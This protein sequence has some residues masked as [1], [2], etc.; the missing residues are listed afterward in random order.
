MLD[1][2]QEAGIVTINGIH[3]SDSLFEE[4][5]TLLPLD[6]PFCITKRGDGVLT[7]FKYSDKDFFDANRTVEI[8]QGP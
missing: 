3:Y 8:Q 5:A 2:K 7:I 4:L 6:K 1:I